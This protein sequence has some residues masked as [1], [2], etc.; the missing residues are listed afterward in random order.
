MHASG[1][2][3]TKTR[4]ATK[5]PKP[6]MNLENLRAQQKE[7]LA[8]LNEMPSHKTGSQWETDRLAEL[9]RVTSQIREEE[10]GA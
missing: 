1:V 10:A 2:Y 6:K 3:Y 8:S 9:Q 4:A 5:Q 7:I